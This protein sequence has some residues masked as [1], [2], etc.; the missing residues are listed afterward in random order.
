MLYQL[1]AK[2]EIICKV[3]IREITGYDLIDKITWKKK[4]FVKCLWH[5]FYE[6]SYL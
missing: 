5:V 3:K 6:M 2:I 4:F 1:K